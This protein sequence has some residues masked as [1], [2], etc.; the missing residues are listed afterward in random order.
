MKLGALAAWIARAAFPAA[1]GA[2]FGGGVAA[3]AALAAKARA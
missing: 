3:V 2:V 1:T